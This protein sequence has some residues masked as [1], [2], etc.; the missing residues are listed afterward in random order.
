MCYYVIAQ[1]Q[2]CNDDDDDDDVALR[3]CGLNPL[4]DY[5]DVKTCDI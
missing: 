2:H 5:F 1:S 4:R 3:T